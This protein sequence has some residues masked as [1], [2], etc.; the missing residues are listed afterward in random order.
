MIKIKLITAKRIVAQGQVHPLQRARSELHDLGYS[1]VENKC[2]YTMAQTYIVNSKMDKAREFLG[3]IQTP[4]ILLDDAASTGTQKMRFLRIPG[5]IGYI[6]K[7]LLR[8]RYLYKQRYPR[9][10]YH[11][12]LL[13]R[14][15]SALDGSVAK[16][17]YVDDEVLTKVH[18]G[19]NLGLAQRVGMTIGKPPS[20]TDQ[21]DIDIH[22]SIRPKHK[23]RIETDNIGKIDN[24]YTYH[25]V[26]CCSQFDRIVAKHGFSES[27]KAF[28]REYLNKMT[29]SKMCLS[30]LGLG[31]ICWRDFEAISAG[32]VLIKPDM[33]HIET[34]PD[35]FV[36]WETYIPVAWDW[37]DL[38]DVLVEVSSNYNKY[39]EV[40]KTAF[41]VV[42]DAWDNGVFARRFD[43]T[44]KKIL[45]G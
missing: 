23:S 7:Q 26:G 18:L 24:H 11:Y 27:G 12:Y 3:Q 6:K 28:G 35:V 22:F 36:P 17:R 4:I 37:S 21:R 41:E 40:A 16:D 2:D 8:K 29:Q 15:S 32:A 19:W 44:M 34:W 1:F 20:F 38:E 13:A 42:Q 9:K 33:D 5:V 45:E 10:R 39:R 43:D 31:E 30:P 14:L 25:R